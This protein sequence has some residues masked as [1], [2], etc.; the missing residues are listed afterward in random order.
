MAFSSP[1]NKEKIIPE[2]SKLLHSLNSLEKE[3][4]VSFTYRRSMYNNNE[5]MQLFDAL[6]EISQREKD[7]MAAIG[8]SKILLENNETNSAKII[9]L[10]IENN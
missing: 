4:S 6:N 1:R 2:P 5:Q 10:E 3:L 7:L 8:I 9:D